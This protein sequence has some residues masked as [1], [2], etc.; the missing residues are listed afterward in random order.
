MRVAVCVASHDRPLR[1]RWLLNALEGQDA[2]VIVG[3]DGCEET[4]ALLRS[5]GV[6][7]VRLARGTGTPGANRNAAWRLAEADLIAFTDDDCRPAPDWIAR[8]RAA[9]ERAPGAVVQGTTAPDPDELGLVALHGWRSQDV[10]PPTPWGQACNIAYPRALLE[11]LGGFDEAMRAGEDADLLAR[12]LA[13]GARHVAAPEALVWHAVEV[14]PLP[15]RVRGAQRWAD[16]ALLVRRHPQLRAGF[17]ARVFWKERHAWLALALAGVAV[18]AA[19]GRRGP[20]AAGRRGPRA[21]AL[22]AAAL[23]AL[24]YARAAAPSYGPH[25]RGRARAA[26][27][28]PLCALADLAEMAALARGSVRHRTLVL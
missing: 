21:A 23:A 6:R 16:V 19:A 22:A 7:H 1:L 18:G 24:P 4:E 11:E 15:A 28:L 14:A 12:A 9:A 20:R 3:H 27:E 17:P 26:A 2:E 8:L 5:R 13:A 10:R 25:P